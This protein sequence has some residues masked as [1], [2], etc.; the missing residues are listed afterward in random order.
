M[1]KT[2][3]QTKPFDAVQAMRDV[4]EKL[5]QRYWQHIDVL[6]SDLEKVSSKRKASGKRQA[7]RSKP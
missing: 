2:A 7:T 1:S 6:K 5:S 3:V 4:R